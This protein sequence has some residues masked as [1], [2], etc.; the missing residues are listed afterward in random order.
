MGQLQNEIKSGVEHK[1]YFEKCL[2]KRSYARD[3]TEAE[4]HIGITREN[5]RG[6]QRRLQ[7][8]QE[9][10][11][12]VIVQAVN[13][14]AELGRYD[15]RSVVEPAIER[16]KWDIKVAAEVFVKDCS[17]IELGCFGCK[18]IA[19]AEVGEDNDHEVLLMTW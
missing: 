1:P 2:S 9:E 12:P 5:I 19:V 11:R 10:Q 18:G 4:E 3:P 14:A 13:V 7:V 17:E 15:K 16:K 6:K 8:L